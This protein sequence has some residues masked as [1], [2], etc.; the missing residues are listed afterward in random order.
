[1]EDNANNRHDVLVFTKTDTSF[2]WQHSTIWLT[3]CNGH[4]RQ[5]IDQAYVVSCNFT[6]MF[7]WFCC[8]SDPEYE[9]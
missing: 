7:R 8:A 5:E 3:E 6:E 4:R 2:Y 9:V 1:M